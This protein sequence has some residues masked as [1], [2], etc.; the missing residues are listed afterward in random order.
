MSVYR[1]NNDY[2]DNELIIYGQC[3]GYG[4]R[5]HK[6]IQELI[7]TKEFYSLDEQIQKDLTEWHEQGKKLPKSLLKIKGKHLINYILDEVNDL[8][9]HTKIYVMQRQEEEMGKA[10][11]ENNY[12]NY[13]ILFHDYGDRWDGLKN[14]LNSCN[15]LIMIHG[16]IIIK[17]SVMKDILKSREESPADIITAAVNVDEKI[18]VENDYV[19]EF[20]HGFKKLI[21]P[22]RYYNRKF[23]DV[24]N[25]YLE[26]HT[27]D[28]N[29][30]GENSLYKTALETGLKIKLINCKED[31]VINVN[32][33]NR[34]FIAYDLL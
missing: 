7:D 20:N 13:S 25:K 32:D 3:G 16:D 6:E 23:I 5:L 9:I 27:F 8:G 2:K 31:E 10:L 11:D 26:T 17:K 30:F 24:I 18:M 12:D 34:Y 29:N 33:I 28:G 22:P 15:E 21:V 4:T 14:E 19:T 1:G